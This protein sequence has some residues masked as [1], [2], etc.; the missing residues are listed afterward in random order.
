M[1]TSWAI[2]QLMETLMAS[3]PRRGRRLLVIGA[4]P[5]IYCRFLWSCGFDV[6]LA[7]PSARIVAEAR[8]SLGTTADIHL[9]QPDHLPWEEDAVDYA[10]VLFAMTPKN[11]QA[12]ITEAVRVA[13]SGV[14]LVFGDTLALARPFAPSLPQAGPWWVLR[15]L[16][17]LAHPAGHLRSASV[18][19]SLRLPWGAKTLLVPP[20]IGPCCG[21]LHD[22]SPTPATTPLWAWRH[23]M[24]VS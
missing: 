3:W 2:E 18:I 21:I 22:F 14:M 5:G 9:A 15:R 17:R 23:G 7:A 10:L 12:V 8:Q 1:T 20:G 4:D 16:L 11:R 19:P 24:E 13:H 6:V